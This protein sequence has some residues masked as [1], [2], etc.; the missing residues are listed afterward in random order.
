MKKYISV[1]VFFFIL[2]SCKDEPSDLIHNSDSVTKAIVNGVNE[3]SSPSFKLVN[4]RGCTTFEVECSVTDIYYLS[5]WME[6]PIVNGRLQEY[7][8]EINGVLNENT[9][10]PNSAAW[11]SLI[12]TNDSNVAA[13]VSLRKGLNTISILSIDRETVNIG[14]IKVSLNIHNAK[15]DDSEYKKYLNQILQNGRVDI[16]DITTFETLGEIYDFSLNRGVFYTYTLSLSGLEP[17]QHLTFTTSLMNNAIPHVIE[18][19][20]NDLN[21]LGASNYSWIVSGNPGATLDVVLPNCKGDYT[22]RIRSHNGSVGVVNLTYIERLGSQEFTREYKSCLVYGGNIFSLNRKISGN[23]FLA[24]TTAKNLNT[25]LL[26]QAPGNPGKIVQLGGYTKMSTSNGYYEHEGFLNY[27]GQVAECIV[28]PSSQQAPFCLVDLYVGL[29]YS[30][31]MLR[32]FFPNLPANNSFKSGYATKNYNCISWSVERT[33]YWEW[34]LDYGSSYYNSNPLVAFDNFYSAYGYTRAGATAE[35]AGVALW[36]LNGAFTHASI[37]KNSNTTKPHGFDW[38]S[39][40]GALERVMHTRDALNGNDYGKIAYYYKPISKTKTSVQSTLDEVDRYSVK[41]LNASFKKTI[42]SVA[43]SKFE[44]KYAAW[45]KTWDNPEIAINSDPRK[46]A[47]S[48]EYSDLLNLCVEYGKASWP[49]FIEKL[50]EG[51]ILSINLIKDLTLSENI[52]LMDEAKAITAK[53]RMVGAPLPSMY[54]NYMNYCLS[55]LNGNKVDVQSAIK[56]IY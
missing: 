5:V 56:R 50:I 46:Y 20:S 17:G 6:I 2:H 39:K 32:S 25:A 54:S 52:V 10:K 31:S 23:C 48:K 44:D 13:Q 34:P 35:N 53:T 51:D 15:I 14:Q 49:L 9:F 7:Q 45:K 29:E 43:V 22:L 4:G 1:L 36:A 12:L 37:T 24:K 11:Q 19:Y 38:E 8:V 42:S 47:Q 41:M 18:L 27:T 21:T 3:I 26:L 30:S 55:L 16:C 33:D 40:C 28:C